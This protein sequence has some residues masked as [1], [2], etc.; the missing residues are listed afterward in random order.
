MVTD[1]LP[2]SVELGPDKSESWEEAIKIECGGASTVAVGVPLAGHDAFELV[3]V[4]METECI[5][6]DSG[7]C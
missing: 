1:E 3:S 7:I 6:E 5:P 4:T 2:N